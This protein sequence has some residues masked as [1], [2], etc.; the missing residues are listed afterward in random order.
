MPSRLTV[1]AYSEIVYMVS[2]DINAQPPENTLRWLDTLH[3]PLASMLRVPD[4]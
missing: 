4:T 2:F 3:F 1:Q